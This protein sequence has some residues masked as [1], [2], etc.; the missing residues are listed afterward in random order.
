MWAGEKQW[1]DMGAQGD[2]CILNAAGQA[3]PNGQV[4]HYTAQIWHSTRYVGCGVS[5]CND[6]S[7]LWV[8]QYYAGGNIV[9]QLPFCKANKPSDMGA[10]G[11]LNTVDDPAGLTCVAGWRLC[12]L[13]ECSSD[14]S[15][16]QAFDVHMLQEP[17]AV[18]RMAPSAPLLAASPPAATAEIPR[19]QTARQALLRLPLLREAG[20]MGPQEPRPRS[21]VKVAVMAR[22]RLSRAQLRRRVRDAAT[23]RDLIPSSA[24]MLRP[25]RRAKRKTAL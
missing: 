4:G 13:R 20:M 21:R 10:C 9:G 18:C 15:R 17:E 12:S 14:C 3:D 1:Y 24:T 16:R 25:P 19:S 8:C 2:D 5:Q 22:L 7:V 23:P 11:N 6:H